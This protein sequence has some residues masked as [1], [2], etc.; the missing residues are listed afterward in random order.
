MVGEILYGLT[1]V[2]VGGVFLFWLYRR[3]NS[4]E[5]QRKKNLRVA[6]FETVKSETPVDDALAEERDAGMESVESRFTIIRVVLLP[7]CGLL[8]IL[9]AV[10]PFIGH[11]PNTYL[12]LIVAALTVVIGIAAKPIVENM[13]SGI[14]ISFS[15]LVRI[16]D[17]VLVDGN[18]GTVEDITITHTTIKRWDWRRYIVPNSTMLNKEFINYSVIDS[19]VWVSVE[20]WID[21]SADLEVVEQ[22]AMHSPKISKY[23]TSYEQPRF[24]IMDMAKEGVN[25]WLA[26]WADSPSEAWM[27]GVDIRKELITKFKEHGIATHGYRLSAP[28]GGAEVKS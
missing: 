28:A 20:F 21:Y 13:I 16:G 1:V 7:F 4:T 6:R 15:N 14:V 18:Y 27:L 17:T 24:W 23:F 25:C 3:L 9:A 12:S 8:I 11:I 5:V 19:Y 2:A 22:I 10:I 26:A